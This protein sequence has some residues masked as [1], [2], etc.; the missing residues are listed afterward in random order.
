MFKSF[1]ENKGV[2]QVHT[3]LLVIP[4]ALALDSFKHL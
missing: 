1:H 2:L 4:N 3:P